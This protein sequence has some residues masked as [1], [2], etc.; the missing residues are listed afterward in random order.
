MANKIRYLREK[1]GLN[2]K[3]LA[4]RTH[5]VQSAISELE[6]G[7]RKPWLNVAKKLSRVLKVPIREIFPQDFNKEDK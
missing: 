1:I 4:E 3:Q 2:Q 5:I 6:R 7:V